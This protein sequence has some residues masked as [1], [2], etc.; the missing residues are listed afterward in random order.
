[1]TLS[2]STLLP[3]SLVASL[4][5][6]AFACGIVAQKVDGTQRMLTAYVQQ[7][8]ARL[9]RIEQKLDAVIMRAVSR[10][11]VQASAN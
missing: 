2:K 4:L 1:M 3:V 10:T 11:E 9:V 8:D 5:A 7:N 6:V